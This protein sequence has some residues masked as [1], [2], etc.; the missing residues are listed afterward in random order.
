MTV[1]SQDLKKNTARTP[2][3]SEWWH[4]LNNDLMHVCRPLGSENLLLRG[5]TLKNTE[6]IYGNVTSNMLIY[7]KSKKKRSVYRD[8]LELSAA[9]HYL[10]QWMSCSVVISWSKYESLGH[11]ITSAC[12]YLH[13]EYLHE[14][15]KKIPFCDKD[16]EM[17]LNALEKLVN[18]PWAKFVLWN[19][20]SSI[21]ALP[22]L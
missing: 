6:F 14:N 1:H 18:G 16:W 13:T 8:F 4:S 22:S 5:A 9:S 7:L 17:W 10:P 21:N 19:Y 12:T 20:W 2:T 3:Q 11:V 15:W